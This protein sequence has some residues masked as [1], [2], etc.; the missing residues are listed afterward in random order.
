MEW[1]IVVNE[2]HQCAEVTTRGI[3]DK[4][5]SLNMAK[6]IINEVKTRQIRKI[7]IDHRNL[8]DVIASTLEI[9][10]RALL[11]KDSGAATAV[12]IALIVKPE[13]FEQFKFFETV[14]VNRGFLI[15]IFQDKEKAMTWLK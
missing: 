1:N 2:E 6:S 13:H 7:L 11:L 5:R 12:K 8:E 4:D 15:S 14:C 3:A 10:D 9:Y